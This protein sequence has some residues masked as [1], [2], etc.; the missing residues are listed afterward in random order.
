MAGVVVLLS[1]VVPHHHHRDGMPC[2][3][4]LTERHAQEDA[5]T[6]DCGCEEHNLAYVNMQGTASDGD[7]HLFLTPLLILFSYIYPLEPMFYGLRID[8]ET[9]PYLESVRDTWIVDAIGLRAPPMS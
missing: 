2:Y 8:H 4:F 5:N 7:S 1:V 3:G 6:H 9:V